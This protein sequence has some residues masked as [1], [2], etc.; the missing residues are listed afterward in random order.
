MTASLFPALT[1]AVCVVC[2]YFYRIDRELE[3]RLTTELTERR[4]HFVLA[5]EATSVPA[6]VT[7]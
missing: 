6:P 5:P 1:F 3:I 7:P 4:K 2:L